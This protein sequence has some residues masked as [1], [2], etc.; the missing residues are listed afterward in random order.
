MDSKQVFTREHI[1]VKTERQR[2][3]PETN[4]N[5]FQESHRY[6]NDDHDVFDHA[7]QIAFGTKNVEGHTANA[8]GSE[9]P[10]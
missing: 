9:T 5:H 3:R 4:R 8:I 6:E 1:S 2:N 10:R 7:G